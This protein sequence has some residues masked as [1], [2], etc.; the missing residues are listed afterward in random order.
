MLMT[1]HEHNLRFFLD[2]DVVSNKVSVLY[3]TAFLVSTEK[4][5]GCMSIASNERHDYK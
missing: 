5:L 4:V 3:L 2:H 1:R